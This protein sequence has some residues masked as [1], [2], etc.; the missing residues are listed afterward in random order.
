LHG[1]KVKYALNIPQEIY[2]EVGKYATAANESVAERL[3][4][5]VKLGFLAE[6]GYLYI[7]Q[8]DGSFS[9]LVMDEK[10]K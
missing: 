8:E 3:R 1:N 6:K 10:D 2:D 5:Y 4:S 9:Q 7:Q